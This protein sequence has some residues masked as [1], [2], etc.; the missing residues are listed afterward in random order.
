MAPAMPSKRRAEC[1]VQEHALAPALVGDHEAGVG[2]AAHGRPL[3]PPLLLPKAQR[4]A[5]S[6]A[7]AAVQE[8]RKSPNR[9]RNSSRCCATLTALATRGP[10]RRTRGRGLLRQE[11]SHI[12][13]IGPPLRNLFA[14][15]L[16]RVRTSR[17]MFSLRLPPC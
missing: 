14:A 4:E 5:S 12:A 1:A 17:P 10:L 11:R 3:L 6:A 16:C 8:S 13:A 2:H 7:S 15:C 9:C